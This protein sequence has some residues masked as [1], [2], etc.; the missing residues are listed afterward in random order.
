[1][2]CDLTA[3]RVRGCKDSIGGTQVLYLFNYLPDPF[4]ILN[5]EATAMNVALSAAYKYELIGDAN[6]FTEEK[7]GDEATQTAINTQTVTAVLA[8]MDVTTA[9]QLNALTEGRA[10]AVVKDRNGIF[11]AVGITDGISW[12]VSGTTGSAKADLNGFTI[13]GTAQEA[14]LSPKLDSATQTAFLAV[15][16]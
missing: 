4:T 15:A 5:G 12:N 1:M 14:L 8:K 11:H 16:S 3:G 13:V 7:V 2:S 6:P 10:Q 9:A